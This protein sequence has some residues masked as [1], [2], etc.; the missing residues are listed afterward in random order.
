MCIVMRFFWVAVCTFTVLPAPLFAANL[1]LTTN[2]SI[3]NAGD[4]LSLSGV[5][6]P[7][8]DAGV[9]SDIYVAVVLPDGAIQ[10]LNSELVWSEVLAPI[11]AA[12]PL[13]NLQAP[14]FYSLALPAA[15]PS[16]SYTFFLVAVP[17]GMPP[18]NSDTWLGFAS[19]TITFQ[20]GSGSTLLLST[21]NARCFLN[22]PCDAMLVAS[23]SGGLSPYHFQ[24]DSFAYGL[25]PLNTN[26]DLFTGNIVGTPSQAGT[27]TFNICA[28]DIG[29]NQN[30]QPVTVVVEALAANIRVH[31][32][33]SVALFT[34][35]ALDGTVI[36]DTSFSNLSHFTYVSLGNHSLSFRCVEVYCF[37]YTTISIDSPTG[38][39]VSPT[40]IDLTPTELP[41]G[42]TRSYMLTV[43]P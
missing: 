17:A 25:R 38:F 13:A 3:Y 21:V 9:P 22:Q 41:P 32:G 30:C 35:I 34:E 14:N 28:V 19:A 43:S 20:A 23:V 27:Y 36:K 26:I 29:G 24:Q 16:G 4:A 39:T 42:A 1:A 40:S 31:I 15:L 6:V 5:I 33:G 7:T 12:T 11:L 8:N 10:T 37:A 18:Q 2:Q